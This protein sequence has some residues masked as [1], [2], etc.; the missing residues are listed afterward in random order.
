MV[1]KNPKSEN[2]KPLLTKKKKRNSKLFD[3]EQKVGKAMTVEED[4]GEARREDH[5]GKQP[6][7]GTKDENK[8][9]MWERNR[10]RPNKK[11]SKKQRL[12]FQTDQ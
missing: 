3:W 1:S 11:K 9:E 10:E 8:S 12:I 5:E 7:R 6:K 2:S 4:V